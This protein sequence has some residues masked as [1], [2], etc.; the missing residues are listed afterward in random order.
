MP[1]LPISPRSCE[2]VEALPEDPATEFRCG[3][4]DK[5]DVLFRNIDRS[6]GR[7]A[8]SMPSPTLSCRPRS[9]CN[10]SAAMGSMPR[11]STPTSSCPSPP[12]GSASTSLPASVRSSSSH[13]LVPPI[14]NDCVLSIPRPTLRTSS[15]PCAFSLANFRFRLSVLQVR[16]SRLR[17]T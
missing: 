15:R 6:V 10:R 4:C 14:S 1:P 7:E 13:S 2:P 11:S 9:P 8:S 16:R 12:L 5:P 3:S 17:V